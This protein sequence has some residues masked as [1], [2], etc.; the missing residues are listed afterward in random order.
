MLQKNL[1]L[2]RAIWVIF[3]RFWLDFVALLFFMAKGKFK[4]AAA[5]SRAHRSFFKYFKHHARKRDAPQSPSSLAGYYSGSLIWSYYV[6]G[7]KK[8]SS[9]R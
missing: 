8:F 7:K 1:P 3:V 4:D 2:G 5:I 6:L 9:L